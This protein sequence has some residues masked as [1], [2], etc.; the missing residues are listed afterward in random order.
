MANPEKRF[1]DYYVAAELYHQNIPLDRVYEW[2]WF[3]RQDDHWGVYDSLVSFAPN[4][5]TFVLSLLSLARLPPLAAKRTWLVLSLVF[6]AFALGFLR[7]VSSL[8]WRRLI[9]LS[10]LCVLPLRVDFLFARPYV[11]ML[12]PIGSAY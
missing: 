7:R 5:P 9:L 2:T 1:P 11:F 8:N 6:L 4:P 12:F 3:Q 10:L